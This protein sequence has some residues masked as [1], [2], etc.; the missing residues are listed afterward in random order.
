MWFFAAAVVA[1]CWLRVPGDLPGLWLVPLL[2]IPALRHRGRRLRWPLFILAGFVYGHGMLQQALDSRLPE[3]VSGQTFRLSATVTGLPEHERVS[4]GRH[5]GDCRRSFRVRPDPDAALPLSGRL[6]LSAYGDCVDL[7]PGDRVTVRARLFTPRARVNKAGHDSARKALSENVA[8]RG[9]VRT[10][11][12]HEAR[13]GGVDGVRWRLSQRLRETLANHP[14]AARWIP[15]LVTGDRRHLTPD[16]WRLLRRTGTAHLVAISGLH[17]TLVTGLVWALFRFLP[18]LLWRRWSTLA[19]QQFAVVPALAAA[20]VYAALA[21]FALP[22]QRALIMTL[23]V[24]LALTWRRTMPR[25]RLLG[26]ALVVVL[27]WQPLSALSVGFW[28]SFG[29]VSLLTLVAGRGVVNLVRAQALLSL[30]LGAVTGWLFGG[31][32]LAAPLANLLLI[33]LF[34]LAIVPLALTGALVD[35][36]GWGLVASA[37]LLDT[38]MT[39]VASCRCR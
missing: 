22:T 34:S 3:A 15:A 28:L 35:P 14:R 31:W 2:L 24:L 5:A 20:T 30:G 1:G 36:S 26:L 16:D 18:P 8:A 23:V 32:G 4:R 12:T 6:D 11:L 33:P 10:W 17:I 27:L 37:A 29:A 38:A 9:Y 7:R 19:A 21:G 25:A 13:S 39:V